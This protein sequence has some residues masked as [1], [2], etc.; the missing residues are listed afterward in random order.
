MPIIF[1]FNFINNINI[2][3]AIFPVKISKERF[4]RVQIENAFI[5][6]IPAVFS[7]SVCM[8]HEIDKQAYYFVGLIWIFSITFQKIIGFILFQHKI[9]QLLFKLFKFK[10]L[11][12]NWNVYRLFDC[13]IENCHVNWKFK[14]VVFVLRWMEKAN[15]QRILHS[16]FVKHFKFHRQTRTIDIWIIKDVACRINVSGNGQ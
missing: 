11:I 3:S 10:K 13:F 5:W 8:K 15:S 2:A 4:L 16:T 6:T 14:L 7:V 1:S 12:N 9:I